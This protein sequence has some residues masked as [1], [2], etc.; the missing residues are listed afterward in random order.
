MV[1]LAHL[2]EE[3]EVLL[4]GVLASRRFFA[5]LGGDAT[6]LFEGFL[7]EVADIGIALFN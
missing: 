3:I 6:I 2:V 1:A 5:G 4:D 7:G